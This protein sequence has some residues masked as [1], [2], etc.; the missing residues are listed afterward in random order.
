MFNLKL[1]SKKHMFLFK[2]Y[3]SLRINDS[4]N[5]S[6]VEVYEIGSDNYFDICSQPIWVPGYY[7]INQEN[8]YF[9][10]FQP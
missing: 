3:D 5:S 6:W 8:N 9:I 4:D 7:R 1:N 10:C 2:I